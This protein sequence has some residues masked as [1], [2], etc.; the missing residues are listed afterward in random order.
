ML[1]IQLFGAPQLAFDGQQVDVTRRKSRALLYYLASQT[2]PLVRDQLLA[3]FWPDLERAAAQTALRSTLHG[4]R[5]A[6]GPALLATDNTISLAADTVVDVREFERGLASPPSDPQRLAALLE[7]YRGEFLAGFTL[8]D[9]EAFEH[10][11]T[12]ERER[13]HRLALRGFAQLAQAYSDQG[14]YAN[15]LDAI[16]RAVALDPLQES[17]HR[18]AM[19]L[20]YLAGDRA[21]AIRRFEQLR[22]MLD[23]ELGVP[24]LA[25]TQALYA[26]ACGCATFCHAC[27]QATTHC[28]ARAKP[29]AAVRWAQQRACA[30]AQ[31]C[32]A[33]PPPTD[34]GRIG[35][36]QVT[37]R[38]HLPATVRQA[39]AGWSRT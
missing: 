31:P 34:R 39:G 13:L 2:T 5:K 33:A 6:C 17:L 24:P 7:L 29:E 3:F 21:G 30:P 1:I 18:T 4:L 22:D 10:W 36:R 25:E 16:E 19:R 23:E 20:L 27:A 26:D 38:R 15:A 37:S 11:M 9:V 8:P 28:G 14:V 12:T 32:W 35:H